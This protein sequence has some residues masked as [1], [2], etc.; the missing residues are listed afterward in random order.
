MAGSAPEGA[1]HIGER[2]QHFWGFAVGRDREDHA[3]GAKDAERKDPADAE[4][5]GRRTE[6]DVDQIGW[7]H[8][9]LLHLGCTS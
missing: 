2:R 4:C 8:R 1:D 5:P 9:K 3:C 6:V 7:V